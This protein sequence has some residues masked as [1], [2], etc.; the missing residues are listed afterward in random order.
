MDAILGLSFDEYGDSECFTYLNSLD[1]FEVYCVRK[2]TFSDGREPLYYTVRESGE[3]TSPGMPAIA[4]KAL[5]NARS[6]RV[7]E[8]LKTLH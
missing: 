2:V 4:M 3:P 5:L 1:E 6:A 8:Y 7:G